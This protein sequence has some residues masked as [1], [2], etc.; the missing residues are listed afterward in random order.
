M[1][2]TVFF[3]ELHGSIRNIPNALGVID[4]TVSTKSHKLYHLYEAWR[5][6]KSKT[7]FYYYRF[8]KRCKPSRLLAPNQGQEQL[9]DYRTEFGEDDF[10]RFFKNTW[11]S[12]QGSIITPAMIEATRVIGLNNK[13]CGGPEIISLLDKVYTAEDTLTENHIK[14][15]NSA[16]YLFEFKDQILESTNH[17]FGFCLSTA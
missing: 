8:S 2:N 6:R 15:D 16:T 17:A 7:L 11:E 1:K 12:G 4:S 3:T 9:D 5:Q 10:A 14:R 13:L